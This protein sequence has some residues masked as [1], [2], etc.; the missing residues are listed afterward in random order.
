[1][2]K[3]TIGFIMSVYSSIHVYQDDFRRKDFREISYLLLL[4]K[5]DDMLRFRIKSNMN[6]RYC[7]CIPT[8]IHDPK[9]WLI[10]KIFTDCV[11]CAVCVEAQE[12]F[13]QLRQTVFTDRLEL[14]L[15]KELSISHRERNVYCKALRLQCLEY[16]RFQICASGFSG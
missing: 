7:T 14:R 12:A 16:D 13:L 6:K 15:K 10:L 8:Y 4:I 9:M 3:A 5:C 1:M 11:L 2:R